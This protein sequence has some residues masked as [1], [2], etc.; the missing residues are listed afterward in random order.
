MIAESLVGQLSPKAVAKIIDTVLEHDTPKLEQLALIV[1]DEQVQVVQ[2]HLRLGATWETAL[3]GRTVRVA[4]SDEETPV[5]SDT[6][7]APSPSQGSRSQVERRRVDELKPNAFNS[8]LFADSLSEPSIVLIAD[9]LAR[10]G[11]RV[12]VEVTPLGI[13]VDGERR[14]RGAKHL[15]WE[16]MDVVVSGELD[17]EQMLDR[18]LD[19]CT[20][21]RQMSVR[22]QVNVY[23]AVGEQLKRVAGRERGRPAEK[24]MPNGIIYLTPDSIRDAASRKAGFSSAKAA[25]RAEAVFSRGTA[26]LQAQLLAGSLTISAAYE[27]L[28]KRPKKQPAPSESDE[29]QPTAADADRQP[30]VPSENE[31]VDEAESS[32]ADPA[33]SDEPLLHHDGERADHANGVDPGATDVDY[34]D[35]EDFDEHQE[36]E[37]ADVVPDLPEPTAPTHSSVGYH[38][39]AICSHIARLSERDYERAAALFERVV[40]QMTSALGDPPEGDEDDHFEEGDEEFDDLQE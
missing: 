35:T 39:N 33:T 22:E 11:Q 23:V 5:A 20:S 7:Q 36:G 19:A 38:V 12:P 18:V 10:N 27:A 13:I 9:D 31:A 14:W 30:T 2:C 32:L 15:G 17:D 25:I 1:A 8:S 6:P 37:P 3:E 16:T 4:P 34:P 21:T 26:E 24:I 29:L 28:P 40:E